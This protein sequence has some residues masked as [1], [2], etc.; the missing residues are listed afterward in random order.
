MPGTRRKHVPL[1]TC[2]VCGQKRPKR[3]L[4]R[5]IHA[6]DG[7]LAIDPKGKQPGRGVYICR[8]EACWHVGL[9][10]RVLAR[11]FKARVV[12]EDVT[13]LQALI[14]ERLSEEEMTEA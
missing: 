2:V 8:E 14:A 7:S 11:G 10:A 6:P 12:S 1:R 5:I 4:I 13:A 3:E 9:N